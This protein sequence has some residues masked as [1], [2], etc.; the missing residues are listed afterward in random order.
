MF[1]STHHIH[2][3]R[4]WTSVRVAHSK[5]DEGNYIY[6]TFEEAGGTV[7]FYIH[8]NT[9]SPRDLARMLSQA[10]TNLMIKKFLK[11]EQDENHS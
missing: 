1:T 9:G 5:K 8:C 4:E 2:P 10:V 7:N 3:T 6:F 11:G